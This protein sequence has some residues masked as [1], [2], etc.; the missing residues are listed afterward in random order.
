[1][2]TSASSPDPHTIKTQVNL[3]LFCANPW[4][5]V[6]RLP[7]RFQPKDTYGVAV[8]S[9]SSDEKS[10]VVT[11]TS[12]N[13]LNDAPIPASTII[14]SA[15]STNPP[16]NTQ[17]RVSFAWYL[18]SGKYHIYYLNR[19]YSTMAVGSPDRKTLWILMTNRANFNRVEI[20]NITTHLHSIGFDTQKLVFSIN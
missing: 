9:Q 5:E 13:N 8:Y 7:V 6:A 19:A 14:G 11:N 2:G 15:V 4:A 3:D 20:N 18:P 1:M 16:L 12:H 17:L 10:V